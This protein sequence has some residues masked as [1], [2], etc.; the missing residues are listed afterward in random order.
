MFM[1]WKIS[2]WIFPGNN[3]MWGITNSE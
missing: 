3:H 1:L 2:I